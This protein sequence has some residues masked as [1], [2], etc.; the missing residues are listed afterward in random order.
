MPYRN[1]DHGL[2]SAAHGGITDCWRAGRET[3]RRAAVWRGALL[4]GLTSLPVLALLYLGEALASLPF[5]PFDLFDWLARVL[6]GGV[7]TAGIDVLVRLI[8]ALGLGA[9]S[10]AA[11]RIEQA[12]ALML[13]VICGAVLGGAIVLLLRRRAWSARQA[14]A[15]GGAVAFFLIVAL[16]LGRGWYPAEGTV[17]ALAVLIIGWG[18]ILGGVLG[19]ARRAG[20]PEPIATAQISRRELLRLVGGSLALALGAWG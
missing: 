16:E 20:Q 3:M 14:G 5:V 12:V 13:F 7:V 9:T 11:K 1:G 4:G 17:L 19:G 2:I 10:V 8:T 18:L 6:P 15:I